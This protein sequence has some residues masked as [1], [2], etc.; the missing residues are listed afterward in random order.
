MW[1]DDVELIIYYIYMISCYLNDIKCWL[2]RL[3]KFGGGGTDLGGKIP[4]NMNKKIKYL[5]TITEIMIKISR[6]ITIFVTPFGIW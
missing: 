1:Q 5:K 4:N 3:L 2:Y 6:Y